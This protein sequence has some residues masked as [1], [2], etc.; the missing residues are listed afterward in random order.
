MPRNGWEG[1]R[2]LAFWASIERT[3]YGEFRASLMVQAGYHNDPLTFESVP[4]AIRES[5]DIASADVLD[6]FL[7]S[8]GTFSNPLDGI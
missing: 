4:E 1:V 2:A 6:D 3:R 7:V 5:V 8:K